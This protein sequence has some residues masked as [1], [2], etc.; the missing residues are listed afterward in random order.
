[1]RLNKIKYI[2]I[3]LLLGFSFSNSN[4]HKLTTQQKKV[5]NHAKSLRK[6]GLIEE[7][8]NVY[9]SLFYKF[10]Y[11]KKALNPLSLIL[12]DQKDFEQLNT[13]AL[14]YQEAHNFNFP[15]KVETFE[16][17]LWTENPLWETTIKE[18]QNN[19]TVSDKTIEK[20]LNV[21]LHNNKLNDVQE[22]V[23]D[24][25]NTK[26]ADYFSFQLGLYYSL[27][28]SFEKSV[29]EYLIYVKSNPLKKALV[30]NR[31]MAYP[32]IDAVNIMVKNI[33]QNDN[34]NIAKILLSDFEFKEKNYS[35]SY[36]LIKKYSNDDNEKISLIKNLIRVKEFEIAERVIDDILDSSSDKII[37]KKAVFELAKIYENYFISKEYQLPIINHIVTN[38][39]LNSQFVKTDEKQFSFFNKSHHY[40]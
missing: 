34:S 10:P 1:M 20:I 37:L 3:L 23:K 4:F 35:M 12:K 25:R 30:K 17:F 5:L 14:L 13:I 6:S 24:F 22:L 21:L 18:L 27:N 38:Q 2:L 19:K 29:E 31:I 7:S 11:L 16:I 8:K 32:E 40:I 39:L 26:K 33:L 15:S 36:E 28:M 9:S